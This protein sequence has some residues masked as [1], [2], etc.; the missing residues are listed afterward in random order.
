MTLDLYADLFD[1]LEAVAERLD[2]FRENAR[3][4]RLQRAMSCRPW[5]DW[6]R[7]NPGLI[8]VGDTGIEP[9]TPAV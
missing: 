5:I 2:V 9:V 8:G 7:R 1:D 4:T 3:C 6:R